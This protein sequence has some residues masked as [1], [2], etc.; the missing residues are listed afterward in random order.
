MAFATSAS[1]LTAKLR[2]LHKK[3]MS[4]LAA[5]DLKAAK[6]LLADLH[7]MTAGFKSAYMWEGI[8]ISR[9]VFGES[10]QAN[11]LITQR[12]SAYSNVIPAATYEGDNSL[13][14]QQLSRSLIR[15]VEMLM[16]GKQIKG[17]GECFNIYEKNV[18]ERIELTPFNLEKDA[19]T[20][21]S[22]QKL[23]MDIAFKNIVSVAEKFMMMMGETDMNTAWNAKL[24]YELVQMSRLFLTYQGYQYSLTRFKETKHE[25]SELAQFVTSSLLF[26]HGLLKVKHCYEIGVFHGIIVKEGKGYERLISEIAK[27]EDALRPHVKIIRDAIGMEEREVGIFQNFDSNIIEQKAKPTRDLVSDMEK[28]FAMK[29]AKMSKL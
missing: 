4:V 6:V 28:D 22:I 27:T 15:Y 7:L 19:L 12:T 14:Q 13:L 10:A 23:L 9:E 8:Q 18:Q 1:M 17:I 20:L 24:Q 21:E 25:A 11:L 5:N 26:L 29:F 16:K 2:E 3:F